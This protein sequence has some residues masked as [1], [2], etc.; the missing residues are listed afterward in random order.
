MPEDIGHV[1]E[2]GATVDHMRGR[3][4]AKHMGAASSAPGHPRLHEGTGRQVTDRGGS[5]KRSEGRLA[6]EENGATG[7]G[8]TSPAEIRRQGRPDVVQQR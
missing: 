5:G 8:R 1:F 7:G 2:A 4:M 6:V 3:A